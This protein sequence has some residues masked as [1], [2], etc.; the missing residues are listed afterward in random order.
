ML[1]S[2]TV[3]M[4]LLTNGVFKVILRVRADLRSCV[5]VC[6]WVCVRYTTTLYKLVCVCVCARVCVCVCVCVCGGTNNHKEH[7]L[8]SDNL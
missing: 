1:D 2:V 8:I 4:G 5:R 6:A 7:L 3:S